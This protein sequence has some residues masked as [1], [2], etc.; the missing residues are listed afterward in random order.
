MLV[1]IHRHSSGAELPNIRQEVDQNQIHICWFAYTDIL[2]VLSYQT[3]GKKWTRIKSTYAGLHTHTHTQT[4]THKKTQTQ[5]HTHR[6][7]HTH[8]HTHTHKHRHR[9]I[10]TDTHTYK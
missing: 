2:R 10:H 9:H 4:H 8:T 3:L 1:C 7:T 6:H 5:T